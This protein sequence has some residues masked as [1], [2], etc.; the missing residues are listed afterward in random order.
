ML[1]GE[2]MKLSEYRED[3]KRDKITLDGEDYYVAEYV[4]EV[5][6]EIDSDLRDIARVIDNLTTGLY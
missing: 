1:K 4:D 5:L 2:N 6:D 3:V